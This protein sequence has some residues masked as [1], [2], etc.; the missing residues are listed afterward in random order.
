MSK[1]NIFLDLGF[2]PH[3]AAIMLMRCELA[4]KI[5]KW[6]QRSG[7]TQ[8]QAAENL[9]I[10]APRLNEILKNRVE[11]VSVDYLLGICAK[12]GL[13]VTLKLVA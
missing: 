13:S 9:A 8:A 6:H 2:P 12:L 11:K 4:G 5:R 10:S 3:E 1:Q 7:L